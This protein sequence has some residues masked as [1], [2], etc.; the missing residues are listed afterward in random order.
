MSHPRSLL[1]AAALAALSVTPTRAPA[2]GAPRRPPP[3]R[4]EI[5]GLDFR[6]DGVW[7]RQARQV[8]ARRAALLARGAFAELNAPVAAAAPLASL[9]AVSGILNVPVVLFQY[10]NIKAQHV[11][12]EY[13]AVLFAATPPLGRPYTYHTFYWEMSNKLLDIEGHTYGPATLDSNEVTYAG[14]PPCSGNPIPGDANCNGQWYNFQT[15]DPFTRTQNGLRQALRKLDNGS[16]DWS[17]YDSDHDGYVD[18]AVFIQPAG[19]G[20]CGGTTNNHLWSHRSSLFPVYTTKTPDPYHAGDSI[21]VADYI[22]ESGV[23]GGTSCDTTQI[24]PVGTVAH[25]TGHGLGLPDLYDTSLRTEGVG[26]WS[27]MS[28][29]NYSKPLSPSRMDAWS[30]SEL[31]W[32]TVAPLT[33]S[34]PYTPY[35]LGP[36]PTADSA[37]L[38][39]PSGSNPRGEYFLLENRQAV[40]SDSALI[41]IACQTSGRLPPLSCGGG[42]LIWHV[43]SEQVAL[44]GLDQDNAVNA[45][46]I[47]GLE[48]LQADGLGNLDA[49]PTVTGSGANNGDAGDP[50][51]GTSAHRTL[52][53]SST[54]S[55]VLNTG[56]C[57]GFR[58]DS[59]SQPAPGGTVRFVVTIDPA[60]DTLQITT[61][62]ALASAQW[63][64]SYSAALRAACGT[65]SYAWAV[66]SATPPPAVALSG[67]GALTGAP[68]DTGTYGFGVTV[69]S[70]TSTSRRVFTL[71]VN[72]PTLTVPQVLGL[73]FLGPRL[74]TDNQRR[75]LDLQ[76]NAN[77]TFD[78]GDFLRWMERT[79]NLAAPVARIEARRYRP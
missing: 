26:F 2:Q 38:V 8:S 78:L 9:Q 53:F 17:Q 69:T 48:L 25:E 31:G 58:I 14:K 72:E 76:G 40:L 60:V 19:D 4:R 56:A 28:V 12:S 3:V 29:G 32:V 71:R 36:A 79:G 50:Y 54:P 39:R 11:A 27:L 15:P 41:R 35:T 55:S 62:A 20:A 5:P 46:P 7:R 49:N 68:T 51:P 61:A 64:Y 65:S 16:I 10:K 77:G 45:G 34:G 75:Y 73:A 52:A 63:G 44:H 70:G 57:P 47:H 33:T 66:D 59:V 6:T 23:G 30:L 37:F 67:T 13:D 1:C 43:D 18:L 74:A 22:L 21:K 42:L 24:M